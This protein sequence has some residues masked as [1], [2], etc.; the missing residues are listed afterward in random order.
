MKLYLAPGACSIGIH[1]L[2]EEIGQPFETR[3][4]DLRKK[5]Q[6]EP[7]Y[8]AI[9]PK[10]KVPTLE[11]EDGSVLTEFPVIARHLWE[12][13]GLS[14]GADPE[15]VLRASEI[16]EYG[17]AT[18]HMQGFTRIFRPERFSPAETSHDAV[19]AQGIE[20]VRRGLELL[21]P[22]VAALPGPDDGITL[23]DPALFY[24]LLWA[25]RVKVPVPEPLAAR[26]GQLR[27]RPAA[28]RVFAREGLP[29]G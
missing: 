3:I 18:V 7:W 20:V 9:N 12:R 27:A 4:L 5:E 14:A 28:H 19:K 10:S 29:A 13:G 22:A 2:L 15:A 21:G 1:F 16:L 11:R 6:H 8:V 23:A 24:L 17:V 26:F 25:Y